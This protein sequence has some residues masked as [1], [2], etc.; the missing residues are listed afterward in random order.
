MSMNASVC[1]S[2][3]SNSAGASPLTI[4]QKMQGGS[5]IQGQPTR[6]AA[7]TGPAP[8]ADRIRR[9]RRSRA[10]GCLAPASLLASAATPGLPQALGALGSG[11]G[12]G[13]ARANA[14]LVTQLDRRREAPRLATAYA[15]ALADQDRR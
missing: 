8:N 14:D 1:S 9:C 5:L 4:E 13:G 2:E 10:P 3:S 12:D 15:R 7:T 11:A 6:A